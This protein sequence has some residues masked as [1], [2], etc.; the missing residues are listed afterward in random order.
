[1]NK[2]TSSVAGAHAAGWYCTC[3]VHGTSVCKY[4][5]HH[6]YMYQNLEK[7]PYMHNCMCHLN[8]TH[9]INTTF[10]YKYIYVAQSTLIQMLTDISAKIYYIY[11]L[12]FQS[13]TIPTYM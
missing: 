7:A 2:L 8:A 1:M 12:A 11:Q 5:G 4:M 13:T 10:I 3:I 9:A 6:L